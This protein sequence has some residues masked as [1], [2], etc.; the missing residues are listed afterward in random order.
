MTVENK[1]GIEVPE[2]YLEDGTLI[3]EGNIL[4]PGQKK[5]WDRIME[6]VG[7]TSGEDKLGHPHI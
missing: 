3:H 7:A 5:V 2:D 4:H 6:E 1:P